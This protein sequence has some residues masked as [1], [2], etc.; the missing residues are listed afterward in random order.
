MRAKYLDGLNAANKIGGASHFITM[1]TNPNWI[2]IQR[3]M[4]PYETAVD[5]PDIVSRVFKL[6]FKELI[7][8]LT[9]KHVLAGLLY[10]THGR[11]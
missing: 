1:T 10:W 9:Q 5:R 6:K 8:D 11:D 7:D 4:Q 3:E 2:E